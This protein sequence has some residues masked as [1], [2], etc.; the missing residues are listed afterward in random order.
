MFHSVLTSPLPP[1][2]ALPLPFLTFGESRGGVRYLLHRA[3]PTSATSAAVARRGG[4]PVGADGDAVENP[5]G[6]VGLHP[7]GGPFGAPG[8][9]AGWAWV[10]ACQGL[11][12]ATR[13]ARAC[14]GVAARRAF[15]RSGS[16]CSRRTTMA[17]M[18]RFQGRPGPARASAGSHMPGRR[19]QV[20][21]RQGTGEHGET[22][23]G[24]GVGGAARRAAPSPLA[25][26]P[27]SR[28]G[29]DQQ[30]HR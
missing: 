14:T 30:E 2:A 12:S 21:R 4:S 18:H 19:E 28:G 6:G 26:L 22:R 7:S 15:T 17:G 1:A 24:G 10:A 25:E 9:P 16:A 8:R 23:Q 20:G 13:R 3:Q 11:R 27:W 5:E 29:D